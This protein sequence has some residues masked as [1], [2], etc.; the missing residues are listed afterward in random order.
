MTTSTEPIAETV[1]RL[2]QRQRRRVLQNQKAFNTAGYTPDEPIRILLL[3]INV[4][5]TG[6]SVGDQFSITGGTAFV[7]ATGYVNTESGGVPTSLAVL[8]AGAYD[9]ID[10]PGAGSPTVTI[11]G[12]GTGL[13]V[14][15]TMSGI[16][17]FGLVPFNGLSPNGLVLPAAAFVALQPS[18]GTPGLTGFGVAD[19]TTGVTYLIPEQVASDGFGYCRHLFPKGH[20]IRLKRR[21]N[22]LGVVRA[23]FWGPKSQT[24]HFGNGIF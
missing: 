15:P 16:F 4:A 13:T 14:D 9:D 19:D 17:G 3:A 11:T 24:V 10:A 5:G 18:L 7:Q 22:S 6:Y 8:N 2:Q 1:R 12:S 23:Y 21:A 20:T